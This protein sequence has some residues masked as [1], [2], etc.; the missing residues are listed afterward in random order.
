MI[1]TSVIWIPIIDHFPTSQLINYVQSV[2]SYMGP[3][4]CAIFVMG[5]FVPR[6]NETVSSLSLVRG[7]SIMLKFYLPH[8]GSFLGPNDWSVRW[9][10]TFYFGNKLWIDVL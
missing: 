9:G 1:V 6:V 2:Q 7:E 4:I 3:P 10:G 5:I 8:S